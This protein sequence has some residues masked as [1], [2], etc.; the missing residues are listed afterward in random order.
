MSDCTTNNKQMSPEGQCIQTATMNQVQ[1]IRGKRKWGGQRNLSKCLVF[2]N[3]KEGVTSILCTSSFLTGLIPLI[4]DL[5]FLCVV[6][7]LFS[8]YVCRKLIDIPHSKAKLN[9]KNSE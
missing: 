5:F 4:F 3:Q 6:S 9:I 1:Y 2:A 8:F 7:G